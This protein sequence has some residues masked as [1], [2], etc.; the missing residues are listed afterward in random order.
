M[1]DLRPA[2][3]PRFDVAGFVLFG[4]FTLSIILGIE[5]LSQD[6]LL[7]PGWLLGIA[8]IAL[9]LYSLHA[10]RSKQPL[11]AL[12]L[13]RLRSFSVGISG[14]LMSRLGSGAMPFLTPLMMQVGLGHSPSVAGMSMIPLTLTGMAT[15][16]FMSKMIRRFGYRAVLSFN[17]LAQGG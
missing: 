12:S 7:A 3:C 9:A 11:F 4:S 2:K 5:S 1:P 10:L 14:T 8:M 15:K 17:T 6:S 16:P 13:F